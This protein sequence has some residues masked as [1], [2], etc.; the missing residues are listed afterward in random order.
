VAPVL[1]K[2]STCLTTEP[3]RRGAVS[4]L[5]RQTACGTPV[6]SIPKYP[7]KCKWQTNLTN[8]TNLRATGRYMCWLYADQKFVVPQGSPWAS[9]L[10][11]G[12][13]KNRPAP[14]AHA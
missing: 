11:F 4:S 2:F 3:P 7:S 14:F 12:W 10:A 9:F 6:F 8:L 1:R 5:L 13:M